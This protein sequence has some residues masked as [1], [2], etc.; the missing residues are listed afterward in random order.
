MIAPMLVT[1]PERRIAMHE[2]T[3][4]PFW[5]ERDSDRLA[6]LTGVAKAIK[7]EDDRRVSALYSSPSICTAFC[8]SGGVSQGQ[9]IANLTALHTCYATAGLPHDGWCIVS[10]AVAVHPPEQVTSR[11]STL[12]CACKSRWRLLC[13]ACQLE[14]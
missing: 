6:L 12:C 11:S 2:V 4:L 5:W 8:T 9:V 14:G 13:R 7:T 3:K 1:N 10:C